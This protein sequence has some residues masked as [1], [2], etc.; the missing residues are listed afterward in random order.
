[1]FDVADAILRAVVGGTFWGGIPNAGLE[2]LVSMMG[3][4]R[5]CGGR[6]KG[7]MRGELWPIRAPKAGELIGVS[8]S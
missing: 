6:C 4:G 7:L 3:G 5:F 8:S 1:M 2:R